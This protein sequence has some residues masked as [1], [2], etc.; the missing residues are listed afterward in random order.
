MVAR[1]KALSFRAFMFSNGLD[2]GFAP[3]DRLLAS[4]CDRDRLSLGLALRALRCEVNIASASGRHGKLAWIL[5][6][7]RGSAP[8]DAEWL[9]AR[10]AKILARDGCGRC[11]AHEAFSFGNFEMARW[12]VAREPE[13]WAAR[14]KAGLSPLDVALPAPSGSWSGDEER[15]EFFDWALSSAPAAEVEAFFAG[16]WLT[17]ARQWSQGENFHDDWSLRMLEERAP[18]PTPEQTA[19]IALILAEPEAARDEFAASFFLRALARA[20]KVQVESAT[21]PAPSAPARRSL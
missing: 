17:A 6:A 13:A 11:F 15:K 12:C 19:K 9:L 7:R 5:L 20:E 16:A 1:M 21:A 14:D 3:C 18:A 4:A 10:G 2:G 8:V